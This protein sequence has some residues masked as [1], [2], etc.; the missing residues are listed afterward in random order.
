MGD[1]FAVQVLD[2]V[3]LQDA[4]LGDEPEQPR[5]R[6]WIKWIAETVAALPAPAAQQP[7]PDNEEQAGS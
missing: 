3:G 2:G 7:A 6:D 4:E 1:D 5:I